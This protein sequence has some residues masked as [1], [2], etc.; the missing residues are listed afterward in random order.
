MVGN[1]TRSVSA[2]MEP[3]KHWNWMIN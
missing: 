3:F 1:V 2:I